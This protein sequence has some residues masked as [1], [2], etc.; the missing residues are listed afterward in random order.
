MTAVP[1]KKAIEDRARFNFVRYANCWE[2]T[3]V[4]LKALVPREG[5]RYL[6]IASAGDN[7]LGLLSA[8]PAEVIAVDLNLAQLACL[9]IRRAAFSLLSHGELLAFIGVHST[10]NRRQMYQTL[11]HAMSPSAQS[12]WDA[13]L[14]AVDTGIIFQGKFENYFKLFRAC[15][16]PFI[17]R[18]KTVAALLA[19]KTQDARDT[20][21]NTV[22][23]TWRWRALFRLFFSRRIMGRFGRDPE[24]FRYV[25]GDVAERVLQRTR[26]ALTVLET[27]TNPYLSF[28][29]TGRFGDALPFYLR[30]ENFEA[31]RRNLSR[32]RIIHGSVDDAL[33]VNSK[34]RFHG[35][36]LSDIFEYMDEG[37]FKN[38]LRHIIDTAEPGARLAY[39]NMLVDRQGATHFVNRLRARNDLADVL[40]NEDKAFFYK[41]FVVEE[42]SA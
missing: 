31:I 40:F 34:I 3:D 18:Q 19:P 1:E 26:H 20:F 29:L 6:S 24:F 15:A 7:C 16:L 17:H 37:S 41:R 30:R 33:S 8:S 39:W 35:F 36:N 32:L 4:L 21:Y 13:R 2:D 5:G 42:V 11:R 23:D 25:D 14:H 10:E 27:H 22:W 28:I 38:L 12:F 9:D